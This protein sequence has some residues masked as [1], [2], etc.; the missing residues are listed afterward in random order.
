MMSPRQLLF[1]KKFKTQL[2]KITELIMAYNV[3]A[4]NKTTHPREFFALYI[5]PNDSGTGHIVFKLSTKRLVTT[6]RCKPWPMADNIF[7]VV[8]EMGDREMEC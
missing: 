7:A 2:C 8:N 4:R 6:L 1:E 5:G 3:K